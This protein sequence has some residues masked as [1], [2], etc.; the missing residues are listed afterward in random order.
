MMQW[1]MVVTR[2]RHTSTCTGT[3]RKR[4]MTRENDVS[5]YKEGDLFPHVP[6]H[7]YHDLMACVGQNGGPYG[8]DAY[9]IGSSDVNATKTHIWV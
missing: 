1:L 2:R 3:N 9:A 4:A 7:K 6:S 8:F 5:L